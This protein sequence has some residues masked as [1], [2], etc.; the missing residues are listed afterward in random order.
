MVA[1][2]PTL[3]LLSGLLIETPRVEEPDNGDGK[4][5]SL[6]FDA[7]LDDM[8]RTMGVSRASCLGAIAYS[9]STFIPNVTGIETYIG[10]ERVEHVMLGA[11][12]GIMFENGI[13]RRANYASLLMDECSL[14]FANSDNTALVRVQRP[15]PYYLRTNPRALLLELFQGPNAEDS[16][17]KTNPVLPAGLLTDA[18]ILGISPAK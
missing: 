5:I 9:L 1:G 13:Q 15:I 6:H 4:M 8:L 3:P 7:S 16:V 17:T 11:T 18:D 2:S 10:A 12:S 14:Y